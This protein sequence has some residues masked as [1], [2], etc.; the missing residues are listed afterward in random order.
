MNYCL[1][2]SV[3]DEKGRFKGF[4]HGE[5]RKELKEKARI[6]GCRLFGDSWVV[7]NPKGLNFHKRKKYGGRKKNG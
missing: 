4:I 5:D 1:V 3:N 6:I 7:P 2:I